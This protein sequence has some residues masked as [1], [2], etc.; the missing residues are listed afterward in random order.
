M[1]SNIKWGLLVAITLFAE[2]STLAVLFGLPVIQ[3]RAFLDPR[4]PRVIVFHHTPPSCIVDF[5]GNFYAAVVQSTLFW[6]CT[7]FVVYGVALVMR[8]KAV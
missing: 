1:T 2:V 5:Q 8:R 3:N 7:V 4:F 6:V